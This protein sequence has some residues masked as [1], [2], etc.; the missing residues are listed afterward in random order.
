MTE[1]TELR[2]YRGADGEF[3]LYEDDGISQAYLKGEG[4]WT[5]L[6]WEDGARRLTI[7]PAPPAG[8]TNVAM[9][10]QTFK[11][12]VLPEGTTTTVEYA[13]KSVNK[14]LPPD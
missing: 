2:V 14:V 3:T 11:V 13:G 4:S 8:A 5:R 10:P 12:V 6:R 1:P 7:E 9:P